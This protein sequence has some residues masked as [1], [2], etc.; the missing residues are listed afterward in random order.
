MA[1]NSS[2]AQGLPS[3][4][5]GGVEGYAVGSAFYPFTSIDATEDLAVS[6]IAA[7]YGLARHMAGVVCELAGIG[8]GR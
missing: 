5:S 7:R 2:A 1:E 3:L 4:W 6:V 8:G